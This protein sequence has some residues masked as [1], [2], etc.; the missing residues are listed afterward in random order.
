MRPTPRHIRGIAAA[1][2][3]LALAV[4]AAANAAT[5]GYEGDTLV[6][7]AASGEANSVT[8]GVNG[9]GQ[10]Q[11]S[12]NAS[13]TA[14]DPRC[15]FDEPLGYMEC[16]RPARIR[17]ELGDG[18][19]QVSFGSDYPAGLPVEVD[20]GDGKDRLY[21]Y[22]GYGAPAA[23][24]LDGGPGDDEITAAEG[25]DVIRG[26]PGTD[27]IDG[28]AGND[29]V[30]GGDGD[31]TVSGDRYGAPGND[32]VEGGAGFDTLDDYDNPGADHNPPITL[33]YDGAANDG[34]PG[35][36]DNVGGIEKFESHVNG[37]F[38]GGPGDDELFAWA[39]VG[40]GPS[41]ITGGGG[42]DKLRGHDNTETIDGGPGNDRVE[43]GMGNDTLTG[44]PGEDQIFGDAT[45]DV[46]GIYYC[47]IPFGNDVINARDGQMDGIDCGAGEDKVVA[48]AVDVIAPNCEQVEKGAG[49]PGGDNAKPGGL[50]GPSSFTRKALKRGIAF[51]HACTAAC[52]VTVT[53]VADKA[54]ARKLGT[55][56]IASGKGKRASAGT[57]KVRAKLTRPAKRRLGRL[58]RGRAT[59]K[60]TVTEGGAR[61][62]F[63]RAVT[64]KR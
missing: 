13:L 51:T 49:G 3:A 30:D 54:T 28:G 17:I 46:C 18:D 63:A 55:E 50:T 52:T 33:S 10:V 35:E 27:T 2:F 41:T 34:R 36:A 8:A 24:V 5:V 1:A 43:G 42:N 58:R 37:T 25:D 61:Q 23:Q 29:A 20:A 60:A 64:I 59:L 40:E 45:S 4:P 39:N 57:V 38:A 12:D 48:D 56:T 32:V 19:D 15:S 31:D 14:S 22:A 6:L 47:K 11:L 21:G 62:R 26:G 9:D 44:G 7:R 53:L 16:A